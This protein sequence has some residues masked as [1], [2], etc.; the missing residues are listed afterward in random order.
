[1]VLSLQKELESKPKHK[2]CSK[3]CMQN[4][5]TL[6]PYILNLFHRFTQFGLFEV[7]VGL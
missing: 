5:R 3:R 7:D 1:M 6:K 2:T 4:G